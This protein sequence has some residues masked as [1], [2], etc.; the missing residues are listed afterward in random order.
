MVVN[1]RAQLQHP[2][3][4]MRRSLAVAIDLG[5]AFTTISSLRSSVRSFDKTRPVGK[6]VLR[7]LLELT[8]E[9]PSSFNL[10]PYKLIVVSS[11]EGKDALGQA[12]LGGNVGK[13]SDAPLTVVFAADKDPARNARKLMELERAHGKS[14]EYVN[15]LP[16]KIT[17]LLGKGWLSTKFRSVVTH[18][19]SPLV[20]AP[21][22]R[23]TDSTTEWAYKNTALAAAAYMYAATAHGLA[24]CPMEGF[25]E[26][27]LCFSLGIDM[28]RYSV[29]MVVSTGYSVEEKEYRKEG[30]ASGEKSRFS[31]DDMVEFK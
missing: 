15:G 7:K 14:E 12:M 8:Q 22:I 24:T 9:A 20:A 31:F 18:L 16:S 2:N 3:I 21:N 4:A 19:M 10:Q 13:V 28:E 26:R 27:R 5:S 25:D 1:T 6:E 29:P 17:F 23:S 30:A 11:Q